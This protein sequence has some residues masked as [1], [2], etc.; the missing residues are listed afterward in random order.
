LSQSLCDSVLRNPKAIHAEY[1][2][3]DVQLGCGPEIG[4]V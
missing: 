2:E 4:Y 1:L 3:V